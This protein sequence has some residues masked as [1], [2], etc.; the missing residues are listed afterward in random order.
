MWKKIKQA[1]HDVFYPRQTPKTAS[2]KKGSKKD[3][4]VC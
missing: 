3:N 2:A 4:G 1:I